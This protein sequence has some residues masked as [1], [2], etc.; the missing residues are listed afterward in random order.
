MEINVKAKK[1]GS[2]IGF[3]L[4]KPVVAERGIKENDE[5]TIEVKQRPKAGVLWGFGKGKFK[6]T[7]QE[8]KDELRKGW[9]SPSDVEREKRWKK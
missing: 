5:I 1:W 2:S 6:K 7:A 4:P 9:L 8:I 3:I